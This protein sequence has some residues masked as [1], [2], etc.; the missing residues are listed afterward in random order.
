M[1]FREPTSGLTHL[2][3]AIL[4][5][6]G[7]VWLVILTRDDPAVLLTMIVY[8]ASM[9]VLYIA[10]AVYHLWDGT[11][12]T[13]DKLVRFDRVG[14]MLLIAGTYTPIVYAFMEGAWQWGMLITIWTLAL[15]GSLYTIFVYRRGVSNKLW[16]TLYYTGMAGIGIITAPRFGASLPSNALMLILAGGAVYL[17][18]AVV[19]TLRRPNL[20][21]YFNYHDLWHVFVMVASACFFVAILRHIAMA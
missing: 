2:F 21:R 9:T 18:G 1:K 13:L 6:I 11:P 5:L 17:C 10:S 14:I 12:E 20:H 16:S 7:L 3:G 8:G 4:S 15:F 19:Y